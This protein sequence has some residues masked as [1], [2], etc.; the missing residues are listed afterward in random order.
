MLFDQSLLFSD[1][2]IG[3]PLTVSTFDWH[4]A[5]FPHRIEHQGDGGKELV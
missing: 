4:Q 5:A 1:G 2:Y 3:R